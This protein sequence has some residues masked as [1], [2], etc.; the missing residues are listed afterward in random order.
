MRLLKA[1]LFS[2]L[3]ATTLVGCGGGSG[4][5]SSA[6]AEPT[7]QVTV[8]IGDKRA[9]GWDHVWITFSEIRFVGPEGRS[10]FTLDEPKELDLL[11]LE[12][13]TERLI[14]SREILAGPIRRIRFFIDDVRMERMD[15][16]G[17]MQVF[18]PPLPPRF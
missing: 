9:L 6:A 17:N 16:Q 15:R 7:G 12:N 3:C 8:L 14:P 18:N 1:F 4:D 10:M 2:V 5:G 13:Y 11:A